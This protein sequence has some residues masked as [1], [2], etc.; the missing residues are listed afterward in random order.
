MIEPE[1]D[2]SRNG[3]GTPGDDV[4]CAALA[5][6]LPHQRFFAEK[7]SSIGR[8]NI[9]HRRRINESVEFL[10]VRVHPG[11]GR[12]TTGAPEPIGATGEPGSAADQR[13][14]LYLVP[15]AWSPAD[16]SPGEHCSGNHSTG[17]HSTGEHSPGGAL[18][19]DAGELRGYDAL[20][21]P[22]SAAAVAAALA[23]ASI[24]DV[25]FHLLGGADAPASTD[26]RPMGV[27]Q[28]NTSVVF[29]DGLMCKFF[30]RLHAGPNPDVELS[31]ALTE[32]GCTA[33]PPLTGWAELRLGDEVFTVA[34]WQA[35]LPETADGWA[36]AL[37]ASRK[38]TETRGADGDFTGAA[39]SLGTAVAEVH[40]ALAAVPPA[41]RR[42]PAARLV[43]PMR[44]RLTHVAGVIPRIAELS[45]AI[46]RVYDT[47]A[48]S[49]AG[50]LPVQRIHGDLHLGQVLRAPGGWKLID[51]EGEPARPWGERREPDHPLR[52][53]A[54]MIRSFDY[55]AHF[56]RMEG[57]NDEGG[58]DKGANDD[59][60]NNGGSD[61]GGSG[62]DCSDG[63]GAA[64]EPGPD[65]TAAWSS[66][67]AE[68]FLRGYE[69]Q[70]TPAE[71]REFGAHGALL[72]A[73]ILDKAVYECLY[74]A[75][76]RPGWLPIPLA[77]VERILGDG[78]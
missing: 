11:T 22:G 38:A 69:E 37:E 59:G 51:F 36:L 53:I 33:V 5:D 54:G 56:P 16:R 35:F 64:P 44:D 57:A 66:A 73:F 40:R 31:A 14:H 45:D 30:R 3:T 41:G 21:D 29:G 2:S 4:V 13:G 43:A 61:G 27:E 34:M 46:S 6:S 78:H 58:N 75:Q 67:L 47:A 7:T 65:S 77:A 52:D 12:Q 15:I 19:I 1:N 32:A 25:S 20:A 50:E 71:A 10:V 72:D 28:S 68:A 17:E 42:V 55:A 39:A 18:L 76:H 62:D 48:E 63:G 74:E 9:V 70:M 23:S 26:A 49:C 8:V 60:S 24:S